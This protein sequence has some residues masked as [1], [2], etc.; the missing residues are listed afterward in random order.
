MTKGNIL[1]RLVFV[2][3]NWKRMS[4]AQRKKYIV[5]YSPSIEC[6]VLGKRDVEWIMKIVRTAEKKQGGIDEDS[7]GTEN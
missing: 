4:S 7:N 1:N 3:R 6:A 2:I 5:K